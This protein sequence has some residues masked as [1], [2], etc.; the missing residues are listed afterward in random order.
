MLAECQVNNKL[1]LF[2]R[3]SGVF[4]TSSW[5]IPHIDAPVLNRRL[6]VTHGSR[7][8]SMTLPAFITAEAGSGRQFRSGAFSPDRGRWLA[9]AGLAS[10]SNFLEVWVFPQATISGNVLSGADAMDSEP[11]S[12]LIL[13]QIRRDAPS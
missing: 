1:T 8:I 11:N 5:R 12:D 9:L 2:G 7:I 10:N 13:D 6:L 3:V 4:N